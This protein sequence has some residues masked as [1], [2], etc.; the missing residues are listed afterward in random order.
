[1]LNSLGES[2][3]SAMVAVDT[4]INYCT[5]GKFST[6][7]ALVDKFISDLNN[8]ASYTDFLRDYC[9]IILDNEDTGAITGSD[10]RRK[11]TL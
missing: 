3:L 9:D 5:G 8:S 1:M 4:A 10:A 2:T 7:D 6:T 11:W